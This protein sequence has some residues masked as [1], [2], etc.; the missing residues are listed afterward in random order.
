MSRARFAFAAHPD[1]IADLRELPDSIRDLALLE[2]QNLVHGSNDCLPLQGRLAGYHKVYVDPS[3]AYRMVI[4]FRQAPPT[5]THKREIYLVAAG[6]RHDYAVYRAAHQRTGP[7]Q[8]V[9][10][11]SAAEARVRAARSRSVL[12]PD[13]TAAG[14]TTSPLAAAPSPAAAP[15]KASQ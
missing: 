7:Q 13:R 9:G 1:A 10:A 15:R 4:Q 14:P 6:S 3:V 11:D 12:A 5:S 2:L 8:G